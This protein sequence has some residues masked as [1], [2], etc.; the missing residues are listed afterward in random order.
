[1][2]DST[3]DASF[4]EWRRIINPLTKENGEI[5]HLTGHVIRLSEVLSQVEEIGGQ[6]RSLAAAKQEMSQQLKGLVVEGRRIAA[7]LKTGLREHHGRKAERLTEY[8]L[9]PFRGNKTA[10]LE[11]P[12]EAEP[13]APDFPNPTF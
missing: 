9:Q 4:A 10:K 1:M 5:P 7:F 11:E 13:P 3:Y 8:G 12:A 2:G 6:Q